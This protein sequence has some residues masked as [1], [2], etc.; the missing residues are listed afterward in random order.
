ML[1]DDIDKNNML[2][3]ISPTDL[4]SYGLIPE[5][6]GRMPILTYLNPLDRATLRRILTEPKDS[7]MKQYTKLFELDKIKIQF[8]EDVL[9]YIVDKAIE[10][11]LGARGLRSI[12]EAMMIDAMYE[13]PSK[14]VNELTITLD[15]ARE[16]MEK[17]NMGRLKAA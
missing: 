1:K 3:Y 17:A 2:Q 9:E 11:K 15:Y 6:V 8:N 7:I 13:L 12:C 16:Q 10:Y 14:D 5:I 4:K